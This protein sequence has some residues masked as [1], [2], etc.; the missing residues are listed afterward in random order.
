MA[1]QFEDAFWLAAEVYVGPLDAG[2]ENWKSETRRLR[3][4]RC[5]MGD[6]HP[7]GTWMRVSVVFQR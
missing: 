3:D 2:L 5:V 7:Q 6:A 1:G 4:G